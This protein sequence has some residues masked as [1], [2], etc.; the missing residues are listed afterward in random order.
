PPL[1]QAVLACLAAEP[2]RVWSTSQLVDAVW[3][4]EPPD[5][6]EASLNTY[7]WGLRRLLGQEALVRTSGGGYQLQ[8]DGGSDVAAARAA[9]A[10]ASRLVADGEPERAAQVLTTVL[11]SWRGETLLGVPGPGAEMLRSELHNLRVALS[12]QNAGLLLALQRPQDAAAAVE[13]VVHA[14]P[15]QERAGELLVTALAAA[16]RRSQA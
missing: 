12:E 11:A 14:D 3:G 6:P 5:R 15:L 2:G 4:E 13:D 8:L 7:V 9:A 1:R 16:G 10:E